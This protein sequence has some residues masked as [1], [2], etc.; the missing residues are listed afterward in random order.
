M[1]FRGSST[2]R[3]SGPGGRISPLRTGQLAARA[4]V[5]PRRRHQPERGNHMRKS[6]RCVLI[7][8]VVTGALAGATPALAAFAPKI[9]VKPAST[10][11]TNIRVAVGT[12]DDPTA[13]FVL[14]APIGST[15]TFPI[16]PG[17]PLGAVSAHAAAADLG[18][19]VL[20]LTGNVLV[21]NP[22]D[23]TIL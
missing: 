17:T 22:A 5:S 6:I 19:A 23:P 13:R 2:P 10:G 7:I 18:G 20:P 15:A 11:G 8:G 9:I 14:Y 12:G 16:A 3:N 4:G 1:R 21:A